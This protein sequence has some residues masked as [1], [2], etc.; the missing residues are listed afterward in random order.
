MS[1]QAI[2]DLDALYDALDR[3]ES[4]A[5]L[6]KVIELWSPQDPSTRRIGFEFIYDARRAL[7]DQEG[8]E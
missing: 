4:R 5:D 1:D 3:V 6:E 2:D 8:D 7:A